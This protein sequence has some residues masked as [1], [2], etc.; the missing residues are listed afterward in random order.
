MM[1]VQPC[2]VHY[3]LKTRVC[4]SVLLVR[5]NRL[6]VLFFI[7]IPQGLILSIAGGFSKRISNFSTPGAVAR[8]ISSFS[9]MLYA[10]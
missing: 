7:F 6:C 8:L 10:R 1:S 5:L 2:L 4:K 3:L 9:E